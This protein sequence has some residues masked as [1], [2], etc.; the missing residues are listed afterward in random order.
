MMSLLSP[1]GLNADVK[2]IA[3]QLDSSRVQFSL[4]WLE[5]KFDTVVGIP[6]RKTR[7]GGG[8]DTGE[9]VKLR[10]GWGD[11]E[12]LARLKEPYV[13][14]G[15]IETLKFAIQTLTVYNIIEGLRIYDVEIKFSRNKSD[16]LLV[17]T[18]SYS[19]LVATKTIAP[20]D[21]M[22]VCEFTNDTQEVAAK[23]EKYWTEKQQSDNAMNNQGN[24]TDSTA[25]EVVSVTL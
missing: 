2:Y 13:R 19:N 18:Q 20:E 6:D 15:E 8:G 17:K 10:D 5:E 11:M 22:T 1:E 12:I 21:A 25:E 3:Q 24:A 4:E 23:G 9:A 14:K 16:N 7:G